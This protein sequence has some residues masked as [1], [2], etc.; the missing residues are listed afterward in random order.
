MKRIHLIIPLALIAGLL[1]ACGAIPTLPPLDSTVAIRTPL[2]TSVPELPTATGQSDLQPATETP[3]ESPT[4]PPEAP[5]ATLEPTRTPF[6]PTE[7]PSFTATQTSTATSAPTGT[8]RPSST[9]TETPTPTP[10]PF[11]PQ[12]MNPYYL[13]NFTHPDLGCKWMGVA[14]QVFN[15]EGVVQK[16]IVIK[17]GGELNGSPVLEEMTLPL[18]D[19][20]VDPAYGP[21]GYEITLA[22][23]PSASEFRVW[24]QIFDLEGDPLSEQIFLTTYDDCQKNLILLNFVED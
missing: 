12:V 18:A 13:A 8:T 24:V 2:S 3:A 20:D 7:T 1:S 4:A 14:G 21:G 22:D 11:S 6:S 23:A 16:D 15:S 17:A 10:L 9:P 19:P 5:S